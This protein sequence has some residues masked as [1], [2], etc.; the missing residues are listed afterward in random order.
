MTLSRDDRAA[1]NEQIH[2]ERRERRE[3]QTARHPWVIP[4]VVTLSVLIVAAAIIAV[5]VLGIPFF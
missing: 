2:R 3:A 4:T 1:R 5:I